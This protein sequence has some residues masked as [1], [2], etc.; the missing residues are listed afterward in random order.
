LDLLGQSKFSKDQ[1]GWMEENPIVQDATT[2]KAETTL[3]GNVAL[4]L[5]GVSK[6]MKADDV[7]VQGFILDGTAAL[8]SGFLLV[9]DR[10][11]RFAIRNLYELDAT[12]GIGTQGALGVVEHCLMT[13]MGEGVLVF[14]GNSTNW[15]SQ[16]TVRDTRSVQNA[17]GGVA[18]FG[19]TFAP[20][21]SIHPIAD[22]GAY[23]G[24]FQ[25]VPF[26]GALDR[27][28]GYIIHNDLSHN[29]AVPTL[30]SGLRMALIGPS[31]APEQSAGHLVM[32]VKDNHLNDNAHGFIIDAGFPFRP[33]PTIFTGSFTGRFENNEARGS[34]TAKALITFTRNNAAETLP[35]S[36]LA[37]KYLMNS[38]YQV[39]YSSD[40]FDPGAGASERVWIDDP[41]VDRGDVRLTLGNHLLLQQADSD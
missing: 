22:F 15:L 2:I 9:A 13:N 37:W 29:T 12:Y 19:S 35:S 7:T 25:P 8:G 39:T 30:T 33:S 23:S 27:T 24:V 40:E 18:F 16:V 6:G 1:D 10:A 36:M 17:F 31:L 26:T 21:D 3:P 14:G 5:I 41:S 34:L 38:R 32:F 20:N 11:Q 4:I 28:V